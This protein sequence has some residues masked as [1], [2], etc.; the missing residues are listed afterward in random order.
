MQEQF[1]EEEG[2]P[3]GI[4]E[5]LGANLGRL[6]VSLFVPVVTF[7]VL[8]RVSILIVRL[9]RCV[10]LIAYLFLPRLRSSWCY[11]TLVKYSVYEMNRRVNRA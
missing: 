2:Q 11:Y 10:L 7:V 1:T 5:W 9:P 8:W 6:L 4:L 3:T